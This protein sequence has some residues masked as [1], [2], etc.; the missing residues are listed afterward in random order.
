MQRT[1]ILLVEDQIGIGSAVSDL[2]EQKGYSVMGPHCSVSSARQIAAI[3]RPD[4]VLMDLRLRRDTSLAFGDELTKQG[5]PVVYLIDG[6][7]ECD[8]VQTSGRRGVLKS[9]DARRLQSVL[10]EIT[11]S[12]LQVA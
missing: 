9:L 4:V 3:T 7:K 11:A 2:L 10:A 1:R 12:Q 8:A 6:R 5:I